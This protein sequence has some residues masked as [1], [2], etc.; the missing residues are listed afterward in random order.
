MID[1]TGPLWTLLWSMKLPVFDATNYEK[2]HFPTAV[3][4]FIDVMVDIHEALEYV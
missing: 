4:G 2:N 1:K 3:A